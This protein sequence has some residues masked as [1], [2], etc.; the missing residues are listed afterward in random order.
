MKLAQEDGTP[1]PGDFVLR[2]VQRFDLAPVPSTLELTLRVDASGL[3]TFRNGSIILAGSSLDR[4]EVVKTDRAVSSWVQGD[5]G[6]ALVLELTAMLASARPL[7]LP[8]TRAVVQ[9]SSTF[10]QVYRGSGAAAPVGADVPAWRFTCLAG[11]FPT[12]GIAQLMREEG[13]VPV[14]R[15]ERRLDFVRLP[16]LFTQDPLDAVEDDPTRFVESRFLEQHELVRGLAT[17]PDGGVVVGSS[18]PPREVLFL[19]RAPARVLE[20]LG[21]CLVR[22]REL[23]SAFNGGVRAGDRIDV[24][25][26]PHVVLTAA[27]VWDAGA[28]GAPAEQVTRLWLGQLLR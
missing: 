9:S 2:A 11:Q 18:N 19:P 25:D 10:A 1:L 3:E 22:R 17:G 7:A 27:H 20:N 15:R 24:G 5:N 21:R 28:S 16:D 13:A 23:P 6:S 4:Y 26:V 12:V 8:L 14:W